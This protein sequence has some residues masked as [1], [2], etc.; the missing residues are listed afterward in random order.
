MHF[1]L[2]NTLYYKY[3]KSSFKCYFNFFRLLIKKI[4][5]D[6]IQYSPFQ[7]KQYLSYSLGSAIIMLL[8]PN[9]NITFI[10]SANNTLALIHY[11]INYTTKENAS[12]Y[13]RIMDINFMKFTYDE[14]QPI[15]NT[16]S[17]DINV[18]YPDKFDLRTFNR[19]VYD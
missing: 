3:E 10:A 13:Q 6:K 7:T 9:Y 4:Y 18:D 1:P 15:S 16:G 5:I 11:I 19:L 2:Q 14:L 12:Q 8:Q 17:S